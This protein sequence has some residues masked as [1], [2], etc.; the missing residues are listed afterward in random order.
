MVK[1]IARSIYPTPITI[2]Y[3]RPLIRLLAFKSKSKVQIFGWNCR[4]VIHEN[5]DQLHRSHFAILAEI[6]SNN[7]WFSNSIIRIL[8]GISLVGFVVSCIQQK[9]IKKGVI[10]IICIRYG[11][12]MP[13]S[14]SCFSPIR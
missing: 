12:A 9:Q 7:G 14:H 6:M 13:L 5:G 4:I 2:N 11:L 3:H 1:K 10:N 8:S